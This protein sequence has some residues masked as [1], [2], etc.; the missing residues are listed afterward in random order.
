MA[1]VYVPGSLV[2]DLNLSF[3]PYS[4]SN[5]TFDITEQDLITKTLGFDSTCG[6][7]SKIDIEPRILDY[8]YIHL[9]NIELVYLFYKL[10][11]LFSS[12]SKHSTAEI[13]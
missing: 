4:P 10:L 13:A 6:I 5:F 2:R 1:S 7:F 8:K 9:Q 11:K 3:S 12:T